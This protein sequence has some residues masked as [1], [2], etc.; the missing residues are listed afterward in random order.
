MP[1][2]VEVRNVALAHVNAL[3]LPKGVSERFLVRDGIDS[4]EDGLD[5]L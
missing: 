1:A 5:E 3:S 2:W 4:Y